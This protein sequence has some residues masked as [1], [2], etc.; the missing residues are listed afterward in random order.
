MLGDSPGGSG[1]CCGV[2]R[3]ASGTAV[4]DP[5]IVARV[6]R[7]LSGI[8]AVASHAQRLTLVFALTSAAGGSVPVLGGE[9]TTASSSSDESGRTIYRLW[10]CTVAPTLI[11]PSS[12]QEEPDIFSSSGTAP[13]VLAASPKVS[14]GHW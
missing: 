8:V 3:A 4:I 12:W 1:R 7:A 13:L 9:R 14:H 11:G 10:G 5:A 6:V 2:V